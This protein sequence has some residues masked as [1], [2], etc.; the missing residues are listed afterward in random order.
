MNASEGN[1]VF[2]SAAF[3]ASKTGRPMIRQIGKHLDI[4]DG[5]PVQTGPN[6][7]GIIYYEVGGEGFELYPVM[8]EWCEERDRRTEK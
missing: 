7:Y 1:R 6:G 8:P 4:L 3:R 2:S 5:K